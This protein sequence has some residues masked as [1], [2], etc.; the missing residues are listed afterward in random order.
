MIPCIFNLGTGE[1]VIILVVVLLLFGA[2]KIPELARGLGRG[3]NSFRQGLNEVSDELNAK[4][5]KEE[6]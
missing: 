6:N 2:K 4:E 1:I 3:V 5:K